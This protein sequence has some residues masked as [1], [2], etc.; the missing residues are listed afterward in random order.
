[1]LCAFAALASSS[2]S[3]DGTAMLFSMTLHHSSAALTCC[4]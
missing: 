4:Q 1:M 2:T 3:L